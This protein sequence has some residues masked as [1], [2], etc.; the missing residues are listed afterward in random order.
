MIGIVMFAAALF[1]LA[2]T[3]ISR[4]VYVRRRGGD[5]RL[6]LRT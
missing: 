3:G 2:A 4:C 6:Y 5:F 1:M